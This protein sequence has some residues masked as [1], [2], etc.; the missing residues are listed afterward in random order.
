[1]CQENLPYEDSV[2]SEELSEET[3]NTP[4]A[5]STI[6]L[7]SNELKTFY[8]DLQSEMDTLTHQLDE[9]LGGESRTYSEEE[10]PI[11]KKPEKSE[12]MQD[13]IKEIV[14]PKKSAITER[15]LRALSRKHLLMMIRDLEEELEQLRTE[16][17]NMLL[18]YKAGPGQ[19]Q[20]RI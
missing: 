16:R 17:E 7:E 10:P 9:M 19:N 14:Q 18:A 11:V 3:E 8:A 13:V 20:H 12:I 4:D 6:R 15:Q 1:M 5:Q 2:L